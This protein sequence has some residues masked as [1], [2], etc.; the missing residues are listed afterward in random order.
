[1]LGVLLCVS[2]VTGYAD[3]IEVLKADLT[4]VQKET[5]IKYPYQAGSNIYTVRVR[6]PDSKRQESVALPGT[7]KVEIAIDGAYRPMTKSPSQES[8][9]EYNY[10][11]PAN[12]N[13][14]KFYTNVSFSYHAMGVEKLKEIQSGL[15]QLSLVNRCIYG[16]E[17]NRGRVGSD[18]TILGRGL[19]SEDQVFVGDVRAEVKS[20]TPNIITFVVPSLLPGKSYP[21]KVVK[22]NYETD[23]GQFLVDIAKISVDQDRI[24]LNPGEKCRLTFKIDFPAGKGGLFISVKTNVPDSVIMPEVVIPEGQTSATISVEGGAQGSGKLFVSATGFEES[25]IAITVGDATK[26]LD[27]KNK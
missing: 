17:C 21:V 25:S 11:I 4:P 22:N 15:Y 19:S 3:T 13:T 8:V 27:Q 26:P 6:I 5:V 14:A 2:A 16:L 9:Y 10:A 12:R 1:M 23:V 20:L 7:Y 18:T 24:T